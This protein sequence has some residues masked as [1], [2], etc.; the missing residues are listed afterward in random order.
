MAYTQSAI[1]QQLKSSGMETGW[2][3]RLLLLSGITFLTVLALFVGM[4]FG[5][6]PY[7]DSQI[8][9]TDQE[10]NKLGSAISEEQV[11]NFSKFYSQLNNIQNLLKN[12]FLGTNFLDFLEKNTLKSVYF[13][14]MTL[15]L[16]AH[17][18]KLD[19]ASISY[20]A[21]SQQMEVFRQSNNIVKVNLDGASLSGDRG[22]GINFSISLTLK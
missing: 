19:G 21:L 5:F 15:D 10:I 1:E 11:N 9:Q 20:E 4:Q 14:A 7:L 8:T 12:H 2:P 3:W 18:A 22:G 17:S 6:Y 16:G 13:K